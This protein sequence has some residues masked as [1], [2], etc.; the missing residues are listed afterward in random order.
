MGRNFLPKYHLCIQGV[1]KQGLLHTQAVRGDS[2]ALRKI[3]T[4]KHRS[5]SVDDLLTITH[6]FEALAGTS[7]LP[8]FGVL[9]QFR[10]AGSAAS[11]VSVVP[12]SVP[13]RADTGAIYGNG[14][15]VMN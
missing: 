7:K 15:A 2:R 6:P 5:L 12:E 9:K 8:Q 3:I 1:S 11:K 4:P 10:T 13:K 14:V